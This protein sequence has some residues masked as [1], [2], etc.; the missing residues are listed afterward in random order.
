MIRFSPQLISAATSSLTDTQPSATVSVKQKALKT[1]ENLKTTDTPPNIKSI[2][3][4]LSLNADEKKK[5]LEELGKELGLSQDQIKDQFLKPWLNATKQ[6]KETLETQLAQAEAKVLENENKLGKTHPVTLK[7]Q[8]NLESL[9]SELE[10]K[11]DDLKLQTEDYQEIN[12]SFWQKLKN[13]FKKFFSIFSKIASVGLKILGFFF[14]SNPIFQMIQK[15]FEILRSFIQSDPQ[16]PES[17]S[18]EIEEASPKP[19]VK[20]DK[21]STLIN[22]LPAVTEDHVFSQRQRWQ[23]NAV[24]KG[25]FR[26]ALE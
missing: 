10:P 21:A 22:R 7:A 23:L 20:K 25:Q 11:I 5:K 15:G 8:V 2:M 14:G 6:M 17:E 19:T 1:A 24:E 3:E 18:N 4:D 16:N 26:L 12:P 13:G 9:R